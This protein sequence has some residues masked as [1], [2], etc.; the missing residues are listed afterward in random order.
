MFGTLIAIYLIGWLPVSF[1]AY[2]A[3]KRLADRRAPADQP[4][5]VIVSLVAGAIWPLL[6]VGLVEMSSVMVLTKVPS[7]PP[8][9]IG[10]YA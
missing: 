2:A 4:F 1:A 7:K 3:G 8:H 10:I 6:V 9:S 5:M